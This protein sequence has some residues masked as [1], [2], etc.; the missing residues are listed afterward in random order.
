MSKIENL[1]RTQKRTE[2]RSEGID[3]DKKQFKFQNGEK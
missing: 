1:K 3:K 2:K